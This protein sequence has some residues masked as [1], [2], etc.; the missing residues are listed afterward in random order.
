VFD[1]TTAAKANAEKLHKTAVAKAKKAEKALAD[2]NKEHFQREEVI[3]ERLNTMSVAAGG[4]YFA[5]FSFSAAINFLY[6]LIFPFPP[7]LSAP[8]CCTEHTKVS[9]STLQPGDDPLMAAVNLLEINWISIQE[10]FELVN[11]VLTRMFVGSW[12]K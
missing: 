2:A 1:S 4:T 12:P 10:V 8:L 7:C 6:S 5:L 11:R 3:A 9:L